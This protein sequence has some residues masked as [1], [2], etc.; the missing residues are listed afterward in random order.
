[1]LDILAKSFQEKSKE[2]NDWFEKKAQGVLLPVTSS[3]DIRNAGF[4]VTVVDT[5][6]FPAGFNNLCNSFSKTAAEQFK[7]TFQEQ[8][9][10]AKKILIIPESFT[11]NWNY[12]EHLKKLEKLLQM[13]GFE[14]A[15][16]Y[17]GDSLP[18]SPYEVTLPSGEKIVLQNVE[19]RNSRLHVASL[20]PDILLLNND[21]SAGIPEILQN[22]TQPIFPSPELGWH[23]RSKKRHF[24]IYCTLIEEVAKILETDCWRM[25]P[26]TYCEH[27]VDINNPKD[28]ERV[29]ERVT[30]VLER[31]KTKYEKYGIDEKPYVFIKSN[32]GTF[33]MGLTH[34]ESAEEV[35]SLN[36]KGKQKLT[37]SKGGIT[38]TEFII[39]EGIITIDS[40]EGAP[41]EPVLYHVG[42]EFVGGFFRIHEK[43]DARASLN[44]PG[45]RF[46]S[47]CFHKTKDT[48]QSELVIHCKDHEHFFVIARWLGKIATLAAGLELKGL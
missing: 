30:K 20:D 34:V 8:A 16:G 23:S 42:G 29:A 27:N 37:S 41:I 18:Q 3:V 40:F 46:E 21:C 1:M 24:E 39:Q 43:K 32:A 2:L 25:C 36:R 26:I 28:L 12:L 5:N 35:T 10:K 9:P 13:A 33:G 17:L 22:L 48:K 7:K 44:A 45:A 38:P 11:R 47:L 6:L 31:T 15:I 19:K 14:T 4:K